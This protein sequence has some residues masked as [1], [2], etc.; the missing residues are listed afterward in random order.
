MNIINILDALTKEELEQINLD[1]E[2][3]EVTLDYFMEEFF[4]FDYNVEEYSKIAS[5][6]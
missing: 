3:L 6:S 2:T 4:G 5:A 1:C